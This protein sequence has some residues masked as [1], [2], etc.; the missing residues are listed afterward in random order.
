MNNKHIIS[1]V[2]GFIA[3]IVGIYC[4]YK[5]GQEKDADSYIVSPPYLS[6]YKAK[7]IKNNFLSKGGKDNLHS[8][9]F[10]YRDKGYPFNK[11]MI[12]FCI[13]AAN[14]FNIDEGY[15]FT[16]RRLKDIMK[17]D[18]TTKDAKFIIHDMYTDFLKRGLE[19]CP[20]RF[21]SFM[22]QVKPDSFVYYNPKIDTILNKNSINEE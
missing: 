11:E 5:I 2:V 19:V 10:Y 16:L 7:I 22:D 21:Y 20:L 18:V 3:F 14:R 17:E 9:L 15:I 8:L 12:Y 4:N 13:I 1:F 6:E